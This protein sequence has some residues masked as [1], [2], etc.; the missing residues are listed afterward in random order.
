MLIQ[1]TLRKADDYGEGHF[2]ASRGS[3][4][5]KGVDYAVEAGATVCSTVFGIVSKL[6]YPYS[7]DLSY[8]YID[9]EDQ[10]GF[11]HRY[12]YVKPDCKVGDKIRIGDAI[13][14]CQDS[15]PR[16]NKNGKTITNHVHYEVLKYKDG[17]KDYQ[18]P[19]K[20]YRI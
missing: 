4:T 10:Q 3:R 9:I 19:N 13:G 7:D 18:D 14:T 6:G 11:H 2:G 8:R 17:K 16:Y 20:F 5:H 1:S 12:F 15:A